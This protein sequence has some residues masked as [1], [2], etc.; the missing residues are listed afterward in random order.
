MPQA[1]LSVLHRYPTPTIANAI[2]LFEVRP[3]NQG[4]LRFGFECLLP[5]LPPVAGYAATCMIA[6]ERL[7]SFGRIEAFEYW[8]HV[9]SVPAPRISVV[10]SLDPYPATGSF[11]G[12]VNANIHKVLGAAG[13]VTNSG[14]RDLAEMRA[15][16]FQALYRHAV[17][18]HSYVH[19]VDYGKE[20]DFEGVVIK[21]GDLLQMDMHGVLVVPPDTLPHLEQ[22]VREVESRERPVIDYCKQPG[23]NRAGLVHA[24][25]RHLR[26][27]PRWEPK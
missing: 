3:R 24:V 13:T 20:I 8:E 22:A 17:V 19:V 27:N 14:V 18:S 4:F 1:D 21:P 7:D 5:D 6:S 23:A 2:E 10:W 25:S 12:E 9:E 11:W 26:N 15:L 16:G